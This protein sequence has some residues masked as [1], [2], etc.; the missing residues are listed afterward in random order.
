M[1]ISAVPLRTFADLSPTEFEN[2]VFDIL[3][4]SN[5]RNLTR[6]TPGSDG[7]RDIE[8]EIFVQD[9][10]GFNLRQRWYFECKR[11]SSSLDWPLVYAKVAHADT[12]GADFLLVVTNSMPSPACESQIANWNNS[13]RSPQIRFW[14]GYELDFIAGQYPA[15]ASK[16]GLRLP[17]E[18]LVGEFLDAALEIAKISQAAYAAAVLGTDALPAIE[19]SSALSEL[20]SLR[21]TQ[22]GK[23]GRFVDLDQEQQCQLYPWVDTANPLR[24]NSTAVR[25]CLSVFRFVLGANRV[26]IERVQD[27]LLIVPMSFRAHTVTATS[28]RLLAI[29]AVWSNVEVELRDTPD[30]VLRFR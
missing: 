27:S 17:P 4:S 15:V 20:F 10:S 1:A 8:G 23:F 18:P 16:Y 30:L 21:A 5:V 12:N 28:R 29:V 13:R 6:R 2:F 9:F 3:S 22:I 19:A 24:A 26:R 7:G 11:Y 14:R 25:A